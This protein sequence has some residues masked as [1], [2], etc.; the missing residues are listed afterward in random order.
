M[1]TSVDDDDK[2]YGDITQFGIDNKF[3]RSI[4]LV[5]YDYSYKNLVV[6][7]SKGIGFVL[8]PGQR[9]CYPVRVSRKYIDSDQIICM[10][11]QRANCHKNSYYLVKIS[12]KTNDVITVE[13]KSNGNVMILPRS[14]QEVRDV[15]RILTMNGTTLPYPIEREVKDVILDASYLFRIDTTGDATTISVEYGG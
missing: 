13:T 4:P 11:N 10:K 5:L 8:R 3:H 2:D 12:N 7:L 14:Y 1:I 15:K 6:I 9:T